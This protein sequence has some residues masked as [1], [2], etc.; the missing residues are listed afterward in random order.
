M[1]RARAHRAGTPRSGTSSELTLVQSATLL[2]VGRHTPALARAGTLACSCG[3]TRPEQQAGA[4][5]AHA[6][7]PPCACIRRGGG[8]GRR[9]AGA[10]ARAA[11]RTLAARAG[12]VP[13]RAACAAGRGR[14]RARHHPAHG[15]GRPPSAGRSARLPPGRRPLPAER[16]CGRGALLYH[17][18]WPRRACLPAMSAGTQDFSKRLTQALQRGQLAHAAGRALSASSPS[19]ST[20]MLRG[21]ALGSAAWPRVSS[22]LLVVSVALAS[23]TCRVAAE[24][25]HAECAALKTTWVLLCCCPAW[26]CAG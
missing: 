3:K 19:G 6:V 18:C 25:G 21:A 22:W 7:S 26:P 20:P 11:A 12:L 16:C 23:G 17:S 5:R 4:L 24:A 15:P 14:A 9:H 1:Q 13:A 2:L 8:A 10:A